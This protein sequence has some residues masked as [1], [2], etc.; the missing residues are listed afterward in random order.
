MKQTRLT[1]ARV[2]PEARPE[3]AA[4][5]AGLRYVHADDPGIR[6]RRAGKGFYYLGPDKRKIQ[7]SATLKRIRSLVLPPAWKDVWI[8][9]Y[10]EG[11]LQATGL[12][13]RGR[14]QYR[15]HAKWREVRDQTKF[16][17]TIAFAEVLPALRQRVDADL[18]QRGLTRERVLA[19]L[20]R[21]LELSLIRVGNEAY[22]KENKS[23][24]L[25]TLRPSHADLQGSTVKF[26][27]TGKGGK[28]HRVTV[29]SR[30]LSRTIQK[31]QEL[32]G[33]RLFQYVDEAGGCHPIDS[34]DVNGY[35]REGTGGDFSAKDFRTWAGTFWAAMTLHELKDAPNKT[36]AKQNLVRAVEAVAARLGNTPAIC[37]KSYI[38]PMVLESYLDGSFRMSLEACSG[39]RITACPGALSPQEAAVLMFLQHGPPVN[40]KESRRS[41]RL[42]K[43]QQVEGTSS[44]GV[45]SGRMTGG[46]ARSRID[47]WAG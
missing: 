28:R 27:Y 16:E 6:R 3:E 37:R 26:E 30:R 22:M 13:A 38:H 42:A 36:E 32:P 47:R 21:L 7:D 40:R 19:T 12:D 5:E 23:F 4:K 25:T 43:A 15:Y 10:A 17:R 44:R 24:G 20:V 29:R 14:K 18:S 31:C 41:P 46:G 2:E 8:C 39:K 9:R 33:Q 11:H 1:R 35:I 45:E 34:E